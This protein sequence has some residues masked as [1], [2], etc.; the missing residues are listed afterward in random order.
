M[1]GLSS[2]SHAKRSPMDLLSCA[3]TM[4][5]GKAGIR[6]RITLIAQKPK[7]LI[8]ALIALLLVITVAVGCTFT[9]ADNVVEETDPG[10]VRPSEEGTEH[11]IVRPTEEG[12]EPGN[13]QLTEEEIELV[14]KALSPLLFD[15]NGEVVG[16]NP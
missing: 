13:A 12:T 10:T 2:G 6:E 14:N 7:M 5:D 11:E 3:T 4:T 1:G 15:D 16:V 8:S 9:G